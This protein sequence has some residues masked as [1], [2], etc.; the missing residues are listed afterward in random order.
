MSTENR[1]DNNK[2]KQNRYSKGSKNNS[3]YNAKGSY[4]QKGRNGSGNFQKGKKNN[5][6]KPYTRN[7]TR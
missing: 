3:K 2:F 4:E 7:Y 6:K 1:K 5:K